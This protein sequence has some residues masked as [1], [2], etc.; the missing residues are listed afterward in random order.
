ME[1]ILRNLKAAGTRDAMPIFWILKFLT[2]C[3]I[4]SLKPHLIRFF[5]PLITSK[6]HISLVFM[7]SNSF[8]SK[9]TSSILCW[10]HNAIKGDIDAIMR[11]CW[12]VERSSHQLPFFLNGNWSWKSNNKYAIVSK[13]L[14]DKVEAEDKQFRGQKPKNTVTSPPYSDTCVWI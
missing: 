5:L 14:A 11:K 6:E 4:H 9:K 12:S 13:T 7:W 2:T 1:T 3:Q 10:H 8:Q